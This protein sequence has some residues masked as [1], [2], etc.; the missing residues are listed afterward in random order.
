MVKRLSKILLAGI[1]FFS[2]AGFSAC[3]LFRPPRARGDVTI[4]L[5][6]FEDW[7]NAF[8]REQIAEFN[9][10]HDTTVAYRFISPE[11]INIE[12]TTAR[13]SGDAPDI[14]M[15]SYGNLLREVTNGTAAPLNGLLPAESLADITDNA[16]S[17]VNFNGNY[18]AF[19]HLMEPSTLLFYRRDMLGGNSAPS[20]W[21]ELYAVMRDIA[22]G[23]SP[24]QSA[25]GVPR[26]AARGWAT[27]G[28]QYNTLGHF[29]EDNSGGFA[30]THDWTQPNV[31]NEAFRALGQFFFEINRIENGTPSGDLTPR[32]Y[33]DIILA[34][35]DGRLAMT[36]GG[37]WSIGDIFNYRHRHPDVIQHIGV[38]PIPTIDGNHTRPTAT[39]GG[40]TYAIDSSS[41]NKQLAADFLYWLIAGDADRAIKFFELTHFSK[42]TTR[43]SVQE[44]I[45]ER[46]P[47]LD[48]SDWIETVLDVAERAVPEPTFPWEIT[49]MVTFFFDRMMGANASL[50]AEISNLETEIQRIINRDNLTRPELLS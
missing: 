48:H 4:W 36:F 40:W 35:C 49:E 41:E 9:R 13:I 43:T 7:S 23:L 10:T 29:A 39:N 30:I 25:L 50:E 44:I 47:E 20:T 21:D 18:Y 32:G 38:A 33:T 27:W 22:P 6:Q 26:S 1:M 5:M 12:L 8:W 17:K 45:D 37:S 14:F 42:I 15:V 24:Q 28:M 3:N 16:R 19:P 34:L 11:S 31:D 2:V 46:L